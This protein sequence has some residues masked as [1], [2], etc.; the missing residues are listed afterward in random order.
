MIA[1]IGDNDR[2]EAIIADVRSLLIARA[3][4][5][6]LRMGVDLADNLQIEL[7]RQENHFRHGARLDHEVPGTGVRFRSHA[8]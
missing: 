5:R 3:M 8:L 1:I 2:N 6:L 4:E 7:H